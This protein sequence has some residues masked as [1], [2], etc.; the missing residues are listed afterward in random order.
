MSG[1]VPLDLAPMLAKAVDAVPPG[2]GLLYEP[3][4]DGFRCLLHRTGDDIALVS[5]SGK[6]LTRYF[7]EIV[8]AAA[9]L[10]DPI[11]L[12][13]ELVVAVKDRL[14]W[15]ALSARVHPAAS[16]VALLSE[17]TPAVFV[18]FDLLA[19][20]D[21]SHLD[22]AF[23]R[24]RERLLTV[25]GALSHRALAVTD[26]T[27]DPALAQQWLMQFEGA[28]LDG[29][30]A[31]PLDAS[32]TPG[33]RTLLK[34]KHRRTAEAVV[35]GY[36]LH[37]NSTELDPMIGSLQISLFGDDGGLKPIGGIA[38]FST[39]TRRALVDELAPL[40]EGVAAGQTNRWTSGRATDWI[41]LRP[42]RVVEFGYDQ[43]ES[44]RLRHTASFLRWRPDRDPT[45]CTVD[46]L[47]VIA[48]YSLEAI[49]RRSDSAT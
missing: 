23:G 10:P 30:V 2:P 31:K 4:W 8:A 32:Y 46:Q 42:E 47:E 34:V 28:G 48:G 11:V 27:E 1:V 3:K 15:D 25:M 20:A 5:R 41:A 7:P 18:A 43:L 33:K 44:A 36:R 12:D 19:D 17:Q 37:K 9:V 22:A 14:D 16:R 13:G 38:S 49:M 21:G 40:V 6:P 24:R 35:T 39:A 45:S 29:I 26:A